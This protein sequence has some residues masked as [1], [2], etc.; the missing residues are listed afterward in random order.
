MAWNEL[1]PASLCHNTCPH[2]RMHEMLQVE[3]TKRWHFYLTRKQRGTSTAH[4]SPH[5]GTLGMIIQSAWLPTDGSSPDLSLIVCFFCLQSHDSRCQLQIGTCHLPLGFPGSSDGKES[6]CNAGDLGSIPGSGRSP[7]EGNGIRS[8]ILAWRIPW[9]EEPGGFQS[10]G[11]QR[12]SHDWVTKHACM[13]LPLQESNHMLLHL[14]TFNTP[15]ESSGCRAE[16][17]F[18]VLWKTGR[19]SL[20]IDIFKSWFYEPTFCI[21]SYLEKH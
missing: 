9:T 14:L 20:Q 7:E 13:N 19:T 16:M 11:S 3:E 21:A 5:F 15:W 2:A 1:G 18:S 17:R 8:S 12:A 10:R 6:A 4:T